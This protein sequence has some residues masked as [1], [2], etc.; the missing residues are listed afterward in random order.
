VPSSGPKPWEAGIIGPDDT[1]AGEGIP[2]T[3]DTAP[4]QTSVTLTFQDFYVLAAEDVD[5]FVVNWNER[6]TAAP[7][8]VEVDGKRFAY[9]G[10]TFLVRGHGAELPRWVKDEEEAGRLVLFVE[11]EERLLAYVYDPAAEAEEE[12]AE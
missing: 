10:L 9:A 11:R 1:R 7:F 3:A 6:P 5:A 12:A 2:M 4:H 8:Y